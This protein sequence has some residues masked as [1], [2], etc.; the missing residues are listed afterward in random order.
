MTRCLTV[1]GMLDDI[2][3][4]PPMMQGGTMQ[5]VFAATADAVCSALRTITASSLFHAL[6]ADNRGTVQ[7][8]LAEALNNIVEHAYA[9]SAGE[10]ALDLTLNAGVLG[11]DI[12]DDGLAMPGLCLPEG[13]LSHGADIADLP[14][15]GFGWFLIRSLTRDLSYVRSAGRNHLAF[16]IK[17]EQSAG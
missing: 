2:T 3:L 11:C 6:S 5:M 1:C 9:K 7:I 12:Y 16:T 14:E 4:A 17:L 15:G 8:V 13:K 10:I